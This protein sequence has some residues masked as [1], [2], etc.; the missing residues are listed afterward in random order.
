MLER[1]TS[2]KWGTISAER[3]AGKSLLCVKL[4]WVSSDYG[5]WNEDAYQLLMDVY[6]LKRLY[7]GLDP[8][9]LR[10]MKIREG[11]MKFSMIVDFEL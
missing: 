11:L 2:G 5:I 8:D 7:E 9:S 4:W 1:T 3:T 6:T 10:A